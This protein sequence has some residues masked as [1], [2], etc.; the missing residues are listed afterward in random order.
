MAARRHEEFAFSYKMI[1]GCKNI[2]A[3][4]GSNNQRLTLIKHLRD[5]LRRVLFFCMSSTY[6]MGFTMPFDRPHNHLTELPLYKHVSMMLAEEIISKHK[7]GDILPSEIELAKR[8]KVNRH[9]LRRAMGELVNEGIIGKLQG[10]G[11]IVQQKLI[12]YSIHSNTR[13]TDTL[14]KNGRVAESIVLRKAGIPAQG[15]I[16]EH[17]QVEEGEPVALIETLR[18]MDGVPF[19]LVT[20][21]LPLR[22]VF[23]VIKLYNEGSLH[24]FIKDNYDI[25]LKRK[26]SMI[27]SV[28]P[29]K[30]EMAKLAIPGNAPILLVKSINIDTKTQTPIELSVSRF[31][32]NCTQLTVEPTG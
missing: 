16:A 28:L 13:Y 21:Y 20:H 14:E 31:K 9:T 12:N 5:W 1:G 19:I 7:P 29:D 11:A 18:N 23:D 2:Q 4:K 10:K 30:D 25:D 8:Y 27:R 22:K 3:F 6:T 15:E 24:K 17:L 32:G 26:M